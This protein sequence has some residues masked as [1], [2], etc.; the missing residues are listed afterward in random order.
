MRRALPSGSLIAV[1][2]DS[3]NCTMACGMG[4]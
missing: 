1:Q 3:T 4:T 2:E